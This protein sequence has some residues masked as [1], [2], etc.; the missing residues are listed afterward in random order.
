MGNVQS[1][2]H[3]KWECIYHI[4]WIPKYRKKKIYEEL[5]KYLTGVFRELARQKE[6]DAMEGHIMSDHVHM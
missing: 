3:S 1:L 6:C 2:S 4:T 5:R